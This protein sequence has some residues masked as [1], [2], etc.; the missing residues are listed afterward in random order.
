MHTTKSE[1][2]NTY[3]RIK[4]HANDLGGAIMLVEDW[5]DA[6]A[7]KSWMFCDGNPA[8][9]NYAMRTGFSEIIKVPTNDE[10]LYGK[11][12]IF[13]HLVHISEIDFDNPVKIENGKPA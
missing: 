12:G 2:A 11:I 1:L 9:L 10:V 13:G 5:W 6:V 4:K 7:G 8:C 3:V